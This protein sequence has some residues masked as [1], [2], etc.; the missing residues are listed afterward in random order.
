M[1]EPLVSVAV[2]TYNS[3]KT[4]V[5][6]LDSIANQTYSNLEMIVSDDCSTDNTVEICNEWIEIH[7]ERFVRTQ[8]LT[9]E[10]NTGVSGNLNR[11]ED[12]CKGD[13]VKE[14]AGDDVLLQNC[15]EIYMDYVKEHPEIIYMF[16][17][18][19]SFGGD[20]EKRK[21]LDDWY[22]LNEKRFFALSIEEQYNQLTMARNPIPTAAS[23]YNRKGVLELGVRNDE[24]IP[25]Y[26]DKPKWINLL[27]KGVRFGY[28]DKATVRYRL[29]DYSLCRNTPEKFNKSYALFY[30]YYC[31]RNDFK[32][33]RKKIAML[34][35]LRSQRTIHDNSLG[36]RILAK[37]YK[38]VFGEE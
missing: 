17:N 23:F 26:E 20:D 16:A 27:K 6:T 7:K 30:L 35:W 32:K 18:V 9:V 4:I 38:T 8:L 15:I 1:N 22:S 21:E 25:F 24:R 14:I 10:E 19:E 2:I 31:F 29:S 34:R 12:A 11:A 13:W 33:G 3:S 37:L 28:I 5:E 36:W